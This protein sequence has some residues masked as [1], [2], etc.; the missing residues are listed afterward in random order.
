MLEALLLL[1]VR[2]G[3][4]AEWTGLRAEHRAAAGECRFGGHWNTGISQR[5]EGVKPR[6]GSV[7]G[8]REGP[9]QSSEKPQPSSVGAPKAHWDGQPE[10]REER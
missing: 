3:C 2:R 1:V 5:P 4:G 8:E 10:S 6:P 7:R 9:G